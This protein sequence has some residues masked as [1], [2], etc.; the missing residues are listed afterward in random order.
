MSEYPEECPVFEVVDCHCGHKFEIGTH[1]TGSP[2]G[3]GELFC[4]G[5]EQVG[6]LRAAGWWLRAHTPGWLGPEV[7]PLTRAAREMLELVR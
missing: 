1:V 4:E 7:R 5:G 6:G 3:K 2:S